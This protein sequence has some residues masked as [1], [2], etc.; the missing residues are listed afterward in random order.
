MP[1]MRFIALSILYSIAVAGSPAAGQTIPSPYRF[2][3]YSQ[4]W[5]VY[6]GK[7]DIDPGQLGLGPRNAT[8]GGARYAAG[9]G[10]ALSLDI[11]GTMFASRREV[12]DVSRPE[13]DRVLGKSDINIFVADLRLR[14]N[15]TGTRTWHRLQPSI[16]FGGGVAIPVSVDRSL[17]STAVMPREEQY[18]FGTRFTGTFGG[19]TSFHVSDKISLRLDGLMNLW[20][21]ETPV[22]WLTF[23][24][25]PDG[26]TLQGQWVSAKSVMLGASWRF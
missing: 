19:G 5:A 26:E 13:A 4:E 24:N 21:I 3:E 11:S 2:I 14:I 20:K 23:E 8:V 6:V 17:E 18:G 9:F 16:A 22:G 25:D 1:D 12:R 10:A 15:L 7:S